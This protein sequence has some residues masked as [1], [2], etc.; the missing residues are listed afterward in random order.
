MAPDK[1][2]DASL[3]VGNVMLDRQHQRLLDLCSQV[4]DCV[5]D[6]SPG[7]SER[8]HMVL[9]DVGDYAFEHF[10]A[11]ESF[12]SQHNYPQLAAHKKEH[13]GFLSQLSQFLF[14]A[15]G[16]ELDRV[17]LYQLLSTWLTE[18]MY[19]SDMHYAEFLRATKVCE[20]SSA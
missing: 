5:K 9:N 16:G 15:N 6:V 11:E 2:F 20:E 1:V 19:G 17:G 18:H 7:S 13:M 8:F 4:A 3:T 12:L 10:K 14:A